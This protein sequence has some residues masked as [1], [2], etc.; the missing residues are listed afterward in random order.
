MNP[1]NPANSPE[2]YSTQAKTIPSWLQGMS[3][4]FSLKQ[5]IHLSTNLARFSV[6]FGFIPLCTSLGVD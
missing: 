5:F 1:K 6:D 4:Y 3:D 2:D